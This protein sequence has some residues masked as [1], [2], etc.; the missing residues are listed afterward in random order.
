MTH[1][2]TDYISRLVLAWLRIIIFLIKV[3]INPCLS[4]H[5]IFL[6]LFS[7]IINYTYPYIDIYQSSREISSV[8][9]TSWARELVWDWNTSF[10]SQR[11]EEEK[12]HLRWTICI[13]VLCNLGSHR[14]WRILDRS[15]EVSVASAKDYLH[16]NL[17]FQTS[18]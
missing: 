15:C 10:P 16:M 1:C 3:F 11:F 17:K 14:Y 12:F 5:N 4:A 2:N 9:I 13:F 8:I 18:C 6:E 7:I